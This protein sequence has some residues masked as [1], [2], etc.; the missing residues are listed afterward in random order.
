MSEHDTVF[1]NELVD[2]QSVQF[3]VQGQTQSIVVLTEQRVN[4][5]LYQNVEIPL[6]EVRN[7]TIFN[8]SFTFEDPYLIHHH[9]PVRTPVTDSLGVAQVRLVIDSL[10]AAAS[11]EED[12]Y[13][14]SHYGGAERQCLD[15]DQTD[16]F[17][18]KDN[19]TDR[20]TICLSYVSFAAEDR[21]AV[22]EGTISP[23]LF[24]G[25]VYRNPNRMSEVVSIMDLQKSA[26]VNDYEN[27]KRIVRPETDYTFYKEYGN[28]FGSSRPL[29]LFVASLSTLG[30][31]VACLCNNRTKKLWRR[32]G[33]SS[34]AGGPESLNLKYTDESHSLT[35]SRSAL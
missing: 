2:G 28:S 19:V 10:N 29:F 1:F 3:P 24:I 17:Y 20:V 11:G 6:W 8:T 21:L 22:E 5:K 32:R 16:L 23:K 27:L 31:A 7:A 33:D 30:V 9:V 18:E 15:I 14:M 12:R 25:A 13:E 4:S 26:D 34:N 35:S